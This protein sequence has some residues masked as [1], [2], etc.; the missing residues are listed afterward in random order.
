MKNKIRNLCVIMIVAM[1]LMMSGCGSKDVD[2]TQKTKEETTSK[3]TD[4]P[5]EEPTPTPT[6]TP[7]PT[8]SLSRDVVNE[9]MTINFSFGERTG[10]FT[11]H[12]NENGLPDGYGEFSTIGDNEWT[13]KG[14]FK[15][16]HFHGHGKT[17]WEGED[18]QVEEGTYT[19]D[20]FT[21]TFT[22]RLDSL[23]RSECLAFGEF[24]VSDRVWA[25][26]DEHVDLFNQA[27]AEQVK[28]VELQSFVAK[29]FKKSREQDTVGIVKLK[30]KALQ[31]FEDK[32]EDYWGYSGYITNIL[33]TDDNYDSYYAIH[34]FG[35]TDVCE[36]DKFE[37]Y[38]LPI[39]T[40]GFDNVSGGTTNVIVILACYMK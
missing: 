36:D 15:N 29:Q 12:L 7:T 24:S 37:L 10:I 4:A 21:P 23:G 18:Y 17:V 26:I 9:T 20:Y 31:A 32:V 33:A 1:A 28:G 8:V 27:T 38:G 3:V 11:G 14:D 6:F 35:R 13:Y 5:T 22:E 39:C 2:S 16:G 34:L 25:Y 19:N 30:L 40:S